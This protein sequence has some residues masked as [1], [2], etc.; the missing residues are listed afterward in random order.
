[1]QNEELRRADELAAAN[2]DL[3]AEIAARKQSEEAMRESEAKILAA[4]ENVAL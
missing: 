2:R 1:M 3:Q 4:F